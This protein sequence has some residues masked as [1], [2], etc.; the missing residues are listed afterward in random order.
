M[1][2][3]IGWVILSLILLY[4]LLIV[5]GSFE[6]TRAMA[7]ALPLGWWHFL[8]R[9]VPQITWNWNLFLTALICSGILLALGN[10]LLSSLFERTRPPDSVNPASQKWKWRWT[11]SIYVG[12]W[13][14]F[15]IAFAAVGVVRHSAWL[16][17]EPRPWYEERLNHYVELRSADVTVQEIMSENDNDPKKTRETFLATK[18]WRRPNKL[19]C[20][21]FDL[22]LYSNTSNKIE[23]VVLIP[24][25][26]RALRR[27]AF[28]VW[29]PA[30]Y[31]VDRPMSKLQ[32]TLAELDAKYGEL[33]HK[34]P[35]R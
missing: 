34:A 28:L 6:S 31:D 11:L 4:L 21:E 3:I 15:A 8:K 18:M 23:T 10:W 14:L 2:P 29:S 19:L 27:S 16:L 17:K 20:D 25:N 35:S 13:L 22:I 30:H 24:R 9:N 33:N 7:A 5:A 32:S 1:K 12:M 26:S